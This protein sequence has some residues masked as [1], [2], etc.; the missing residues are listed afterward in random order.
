MSAS[1]DDDDNDT[2][3]FAGA[4]GSFTPSFDE[5]PT[6]SLPGFVVEDDLLDSEKF[7]F[8]Q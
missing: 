8:A 2:R 4:A 6:Y 3:S 1:D 5:E 7:A